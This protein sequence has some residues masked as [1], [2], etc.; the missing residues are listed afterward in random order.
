[1]EDKILK[2]FGIHLK[3][4]RKEHGLSQEDLADKARLDRTYVSGVETGKRNISL[5]ALN[6]IAN[7]LDKNLSQL[8]EGMQ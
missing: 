4:L 6:S 1:M 7:A 5:K 8:F 2:T 3:T